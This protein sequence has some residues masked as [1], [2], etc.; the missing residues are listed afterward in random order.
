MDSF[1]AQMSAFAGAVKWN[2]ASYIARDIRKTA[3]Y[4]ALKGIDESDTEVYIHA[5]IMA[6][7]AEAARVDSLNRAYDTAFSASIRNMVD[8]ERRIAANVS[9]TKDVRGKPPARLIEQQLAALKKER[10]E[11]N[12][13]Q[14]KDKDHMRSLYAAKEAQIDV[15]K[16]CH[17]C[18]EALV[19][20]HDWGLYHVFGG[21]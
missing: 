10:V 5:V 16:D 1:E 15:W 18:Y 2:D 12:A 19:C 20:L 7:K 13:M 11:I 6:T 8:L 3:L 4:H 14:Q 9:K 21:C 17:A